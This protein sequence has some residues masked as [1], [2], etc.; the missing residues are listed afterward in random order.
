MPSSLQGGIHGA[1][2]ISRQETKIMREKCLKWGAKATILCSLAFLCGC[3]IPSSLA[4]ALRDAESNE[5]I[6]N[7]RVCISP[8]GM[9]VSDNIDGVYVFIAVAPGDYAIHA[10]AEGYRTGEGTITLEIGQQAVATLAL[11]PLDP[12]E[13]AGELPCAGGGD[14]T[15]EGVCGCFMNKFTARHAAGD[16]LVV[17][18]FGLVLLSRR[19]KPG[20][21]D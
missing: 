13:Q 8:G 16:L 10:A 18:C 19:N 4:V 20:Q 12:G 9:V 14:P 11:S 1:V 17:A 2:I 5:Y 3:P 6:I 21:N 7:G 15:T